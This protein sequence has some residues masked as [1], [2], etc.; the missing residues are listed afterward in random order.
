MNFV[1]GNVLYRWGRFKLIKELIRFKFIQSDVRFQKEP[2]SRGHEGEVS[3]RSEV[4]DVYIQHIDCC[5]ST[6]YPTTAELE[7]PFNIA[8]C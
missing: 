4:L 3:G 6:N 5:R 7:I 2:R 1:L 8:Q